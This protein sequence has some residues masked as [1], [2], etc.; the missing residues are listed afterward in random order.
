MLAAQRTLLAPN[1][2]KNEISIEEEETVWV[3]QIPVA[4][5]SV[6]RLRTTAHTMLTFVMLAVSDLGLKHPSLVRGGGPNLVGSKFRTTLPLERR[7][8][9]SANGYLDTLT[10]KEVPSAPKNSYLDTLTRKEVPSGSLNVDA[11]TPPPEIDA[12]APLTEV[13]VSTHPMLLMEVAVSAPL[14]NLPLGFDFDETPLKEVHVSALLTMDDVPMPSATLTEAEVSAWALDFDE[15]PVTEAAVSVPLAEVPNVSKNAYV[16]TLTRTEV[17]SGILC[18]GVGGYIGATA[19]W[20]AGNGLTRLTFGAIGL[21]LSII[22]VGTMGASAFTGNLAFAGAALR[23]GKTS[24]YKAGKMLLVT[25]LGCL[26][27]AFHAASLC[28]LG[29]LPAVG[30][31]VQIAVHNLAFSLLQLHAPLTPTPTHSPPPHTHTFI[32]GIGGGWL[33]ALAITFAMAFV[34]GGGNFFDLALGV[35]LSIST[36]VD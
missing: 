14:S 33:I 21:P 9:V 4:A 1:L 17:S 15:T 26:L 8:S 31:S 19:F 12:L 34:K 6:S 22:A 16:D 27:E 7:A 18:A 11:S 25:Y 35:W 32:R 2:K 30:P 10:Q 3:V 23:A 28:V 5:A 24:L 36:Y 29:A 20:E 13:D